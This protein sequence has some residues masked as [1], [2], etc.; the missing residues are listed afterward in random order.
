MTITIDLDTEKAGILSKILKIAFRE[1]NL[2]ALSRGSEG[3]YILSAT[4]MKIHFDGLI[5]DVIGQLSRGIEKEE[6]GKLLNQLY[7]EPLIEDKRLPPL[8]H[9][10]PMP[11]VKK[12]KPPKGR[13]K[14]F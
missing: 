10:R 5:L 7:P 6:A 8:G 3:N 1:K 14:K 2:F 11:P 9:D 12:P 13:M 4:E